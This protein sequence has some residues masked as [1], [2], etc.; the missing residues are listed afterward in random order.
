MR[1]RIIAKLDVKPPYVVKPVY[2]DGLR[3][4]G[5][6]SMLAKKYYEQGADEIVYIDIVA[7]LY[8]REI[9]LS[10]IK[11]T[12]N[13]ILVPFA[14]GGGVTSIDDISSI[15]R[16]GGDKV[17]INTYAIQNNPQIINQASEIFGN[18]SIIINIEAK[19]WDNWYEC[20]SDGGK[21]QTGKNVISWVKEVEQRGA[22]EIILQSVDNDGI[23]KGFNK[24]LA[25]MVVDAVNIPV[26]VASGAGSLEDIYN[27]IT[28]AN[29]SGVA[30]SSVLHYNKYT[31]N[32]IKDYL[33]K[34]G[35]EVFR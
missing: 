30:I 19:K 34:H 18:Q 33:S 10:D 3:K 5:L 21:I 13:E 15:F 26:I 31:I 16:S 9:I 4:I 14:I 23:Q 12:A 24:E 20:Y 35:I 25:K 28:Y 11:Q 7:S 1:T 2:F 17:I 8:Q 29:P 32:D 22:G 27:L 6:S